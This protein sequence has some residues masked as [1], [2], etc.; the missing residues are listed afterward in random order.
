MHKHNWV[1]LLILSS[2]I[3]FIS[4]NDKPVAT[5]GAIVLGDSSN[6]VTEK[7]ASLLQDQVEDLKPQIPAPAPHKDTQA[8]PIVT[9]DTAK[10]APVAQAAPAPAPSGTGLKAD[11][12]EVSILIPNVVAKQAGNPNLSNANGAV[13][14]YESGQFQGNVLRASGNISKVSMRYQSIIVL[15]CDAGTL[16]LDKLTTTTSWEPLKGGNGA[17]PI[18]GLQESQLDY[19]EGNGNEIKRAIQVACQKRRFSYNKTQEFL[20]AVKHVKATNQRPLI[21]SIRSLMWKVDGKDNQGKL[22]SKQLR[23]DYPM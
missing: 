12:T 13:Y 20:Q 9:K 5:K 2:A 8:T 22:F 15:K 11:F 4:C 21:I 18:T 17:W 10:P 23:V 14:S 7:D 3:F 6:I 16:P 19:E 1:F